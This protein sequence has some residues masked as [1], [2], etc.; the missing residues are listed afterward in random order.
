MISAQ[1]L[2]ERSD[3]STKKH[4]NYNNTLKAPSA[5]INGQRDCIVS[6]HRYGLCKI[7]SNGCAPIAVFNALFYSGRQPDFNLITLGLENYA[8]R[9]GG[10]LGTDPEKLDLF[11]KRCCI[12]AIK[13]NGYNDYINVMNSV[14]SGIMCYWVAKPR[15]SLLHFVA[16]INNRDGTFS[17]CN[18]FSN[19][20]KAFVT[21]SIEK[22]CPPDCFVCGY[23]IN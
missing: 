2:L 1:E 20:R 6:K 14:T 19:R 13:A 3:S 4:Y 12:P 10:L 7:A 21:D 5:I 11:F 17:I 22:V 15:R 18:R 16:V 9:M 23:F 8:L